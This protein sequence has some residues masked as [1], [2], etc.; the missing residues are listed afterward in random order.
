MKLFPF[1]RMFWIRL[2]SSPRLSVRNLNL[3]KVIVSAFLLKVRLLGRLL[4]FFVPFIF[5]S[6]FRLR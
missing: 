6:E 1:A 5:V 4:G 2:S 3:L